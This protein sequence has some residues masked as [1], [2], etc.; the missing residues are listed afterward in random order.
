MM[1]HEL[2]VEC[3]GLFT[4]KIERVVEKTETFRDFLVRVNTYGLAGKSPVGDFA[5]YM[6]DVNSNELSTQPLFPDG[7]LTYSA[8]HDHV[9]YIFGSYN[10]RMSAFEQSYV[11]YV[12]DI[13]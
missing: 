10:G 6:I 5:K 1:V 4:A 3:D 8:Y 2:R 11:A 9:D 7:Y 12:C 13:L